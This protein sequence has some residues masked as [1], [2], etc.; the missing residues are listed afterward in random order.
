MP[1]IWKRISLG[2][3]AN[4]VMP[5]SDTMLN[6][7]QNDLKTVLADV[8]KIVKNNRGPALLTA[9]VLGFLVARA[10]LRA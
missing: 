3:D 6:V 9:A 4:A 7:R 8:Q 1:V 10:L 5:E 2:C